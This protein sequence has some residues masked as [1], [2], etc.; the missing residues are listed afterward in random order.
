MLT[1]LGDMAEVKRQAFKVSISILC[2]KYIKFASYLLVFFNPL[3]EHLDDEHI[4]FD[5]NVYLWYKNSIMSI[6]DCDILL[7][8]NED[9][10]L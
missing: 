8:E 6:C 1:C 3:I 2:S 5:R 9:T 10:N 7:Y 4:L